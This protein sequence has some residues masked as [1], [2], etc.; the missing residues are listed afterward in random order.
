MIYIIYYIS[1]IYIHIYIAYIYLIEISISLS[2][3]SQQCLY[4]DLLAITAAR[5]MKHFSKSMPVPI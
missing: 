4:C 1:C 2:F 5:C 3:S